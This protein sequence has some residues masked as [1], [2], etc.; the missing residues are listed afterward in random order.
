MQTLLT[1]KEP[2]VSIGL[3][4]AFQKADHTTYTLQRTFRKFN[5]I[6]SKNYLFKVNHRNYRIRHE[7]CSKL[8]IKTTDPSTLGK[9]FTSWFCVFTVGFE[10]S[11]WAISGFTEVKLLLIFNRYFLIFVVVFLNCWV[12]SGEYRK[13]FHNCREL[14]STEGKVQNM[15]FGEYLR[16]WFSLPR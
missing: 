1:V 10:Q 4:A 12:W 16:D 6:S 7:I 15:F 8:T 14:L 9:A 13:C 5:K 2:K 3:T 11:I